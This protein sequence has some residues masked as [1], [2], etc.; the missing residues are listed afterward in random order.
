MRQ[1]FEVSE[2][3]AKARQNEIHAQIN[4]AKF[5]IIQLFDKKLEQ[6]KKFVEEEIRNV[7]SELNK[8]IDNNAEAIEDIDT[9]IGDIEVKIGNIISSSTAQQE[10]TDSV[11]NLDDEIMDRISRQ[12]NLL[13]YG[14][15]E[16][17]T[18]QLPPKERA[19]LDHVKVIEL[20]TK[21]CPDWSKNNGNI[22]YSFRINKFN[23]SLSKPRMIKI[24]FTNSLAC[25]VFKN[26]FIKAKKSPTLSQILKNMSVSDDLTKCQRTHL[27]RL[28]NEITLPGN[29]D[30]VVKQIR[31]KFTLVNKKPTKAQSPPVLVGQQDF[32]REQQQ[33]VQQH[34]QQK[35]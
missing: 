5:D 32:L 28:K 16:E 30:K 1:L 27:S 7:T 35:Q 20:S 23:N 31:G 24:C 19:R 6:H 2:E 17:N 9:R 33:L 13:L 10:K 34:Q 15:P 29:G 25:N 18:N 26:C 12:S 3:N 11:D 21:L 22:S 4:K 14:M 8:H